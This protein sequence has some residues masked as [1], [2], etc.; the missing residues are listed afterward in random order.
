VGGA[1]DVGFVHFGCGM[2]DVGRML[3]LGV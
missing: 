1:D 3:G 2:W